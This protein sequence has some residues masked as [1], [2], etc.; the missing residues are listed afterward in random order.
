MEALRG[1]RQS[2][3]RWLTVAERT[4]SEGDRASQYSMEVGRGLLAGDD[5]EDAERHFR[6]AVDIVD[7]SDAPFWR[8][9]V[10]LTAAE[11]I[12]DRRQGQASL[13]AREALEISEAKGLT[14]L[15]EQARALL[16]EINGGA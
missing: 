2:A 11:A 6:R 9:D 13:W 4:A 5:T 1:D 14:V 15:V 16:S 8:S 12:R 3:E 10:R 7:E